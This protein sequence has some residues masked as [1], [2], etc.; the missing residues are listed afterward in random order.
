[1]TLC[2][3]VGFPSQECVL[4]SDPA[5]CIPADVWVCVCVHVSVVLCVC[6]CA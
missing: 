4:L 6:S 2:V 3:R 1:M 5:H